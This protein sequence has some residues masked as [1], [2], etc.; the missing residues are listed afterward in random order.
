M[1]SA[2]QVR[3][4]VTTGAWWRTAVTMASGDVGGC[5]GDAGGAVGGLVAGE[6]VA[7]FEYPGD[8]VLGAAAP[9]LGQ[10]DDRDDRADARAGQFVMQ[11][12]E[13]GVAP[14]L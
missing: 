14:V 10:H 4:L 3:S 6:D 8:L 2:M 12:E 1:E 13:Y 7:A 5:A 9:G 11:G